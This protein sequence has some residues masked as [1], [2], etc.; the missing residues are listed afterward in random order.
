MLR[1]RRAARKV[2]TPVRRSKGKI[3]GSGLLVLDVVDDLGHVVLIF[4]EFGGILDD[5]LLFLLGFGQRHGLVFLLLVLDRF[6]F[7]GRDIGVD[8][9]RRHRLDLALDR[10]GRTG[11][12]RPQ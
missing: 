8:V 7:L 6:R 3:V 10:R 2:G 11:A 1:P 9:F 4:A 5:L 12:A